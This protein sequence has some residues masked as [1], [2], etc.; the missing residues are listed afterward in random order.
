VVQRPR[1]HG[2]LPRYISSSD[3]QDISRTPVVKPRIR[4][5]PWLFSHDP[6]RAELGDAIFATEPEADL[7]EAYR[8]AGGDGPR[9]G[10]VPLAWAP[11]G[12]FGFFGFFTRELADP[13]REL[14]PA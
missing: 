10:E 12:F 11:D 7:A 5:H 6:G 2:V 9:Y 13:L 4:Y 1:A 14:R 8:K 3:R